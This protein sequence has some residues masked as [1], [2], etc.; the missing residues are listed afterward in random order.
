MQEQEMISVMTIFIDVP[1][2]KKKVL[3]LIAVLVELVSCVLIT[4]T[5][6]VHNAAGNRGCCRMALPKTVLMR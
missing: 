5:F 1:R 2:H 3:H 6:V 4:P